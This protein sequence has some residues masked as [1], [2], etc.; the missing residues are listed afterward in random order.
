MFASSRDGELAVVLVNLSQTSYS[1][2]YSHT[3]I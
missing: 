3:L 2:T 1:Y